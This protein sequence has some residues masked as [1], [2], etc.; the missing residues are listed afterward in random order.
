MPEAIITTSWDDGN[1]FDLKLAEMLYKYS[2]PATFYFPLHN[3]ERPTI[4]KAHIRDIAQYFEIGGHAFHHCNLVLLPL[5]EVENEI[6][7]GKKALEHIIGKNISSFA[8]PIGEYTPEITGIVRNSG[9]SVARTIKPWRRK[10]LHSLELGTM[11]HALDYSPPHYLLHMLKMN[12]A[13]LFKHIITENLVFKTWDQIAISTFDYILKN[14]GVWHL[15]GHSWEIDANRDWK[16][17]ESVFQEIS[18]ISSD[19]IKSTNGQLLDILN[20]EK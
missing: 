10:S 1:T 8:Y 16:K 17:L 7:S 19:I 4:T 9:Y 18:P 3:S 6:A 12:D 2:I 14:G 13:G 5:Q 11:L 20:N 15:W